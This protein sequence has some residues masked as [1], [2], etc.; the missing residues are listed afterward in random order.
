[1]NSRVEPT[2]DSPVESTMD[3]NDESTSSRERTVTFEVQANIES[4]KE[5]MKVKGSE[6]SS[7]ELE[8]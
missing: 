3:P 4:M 8:G 1:M 7:N 2:M 6:S 5:P